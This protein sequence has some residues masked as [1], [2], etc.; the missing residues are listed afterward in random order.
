MAF[1]KD[2]MHTD[3][4]TVTADQPVLEVAK[5]MA[6]QKIGAV[7]I[8][9]GDNELEGVFSERDLLARVIAEGKDPASTKVGDVAT[10]DVATVAPDTHI[11][12]CADLL[13]EKRIRHLPVVGGGTLGIISTRDFFGYLAEKLESFIDRARYE[14][15]LDEGVDPYDHIGGSYDR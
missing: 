11:K 6:A 1:I 9:S 10:R 12:Q 2:L 7:L 15:Q 4:V 3:V 8:T 13:R 5:K 14:K